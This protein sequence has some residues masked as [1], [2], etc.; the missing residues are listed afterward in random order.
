[1]NFYQKTSG[2]E[3]TWDSL[4]N[5]DVYNIKIVLGEIDM[6]MYEFSGSI[7]AGNS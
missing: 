6:K 5:I 3:T 1:M 2:E 4:A 7:I